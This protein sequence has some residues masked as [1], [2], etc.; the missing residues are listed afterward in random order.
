M[1]SRRSVKLLKWMAQN[2]DWCHERKLEMRYPGF[3]YRSLSALCDDGLLDS[4]VPEDEPPQLDEYGSEFYCRQYRISD[5]GLG[6][7]EAQTGERW[8]EFRNWFSLAIA[9]S[10]FIKSF[11]F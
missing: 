8:K 3:D 1:L 2:N 9:L 11:F 7:L 6:Y 4:A 5:K 10:A